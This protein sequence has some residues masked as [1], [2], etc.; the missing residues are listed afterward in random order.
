MGNE[1]DK[2]KV[3]D[4]SRKENVKDKDPKET[5]KKTSDIGIVE[6][7]LENEAKT[8]CCK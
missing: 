1:K 7:E 5:G 3:N 8:G 6:K 4:S 2:T